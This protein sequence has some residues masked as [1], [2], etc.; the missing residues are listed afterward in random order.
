[1]SVASVHEVFDENGEIVDARVEKQLRGVATGL[2]HY[3][4]QNICPRFALEAMVR[5]QAA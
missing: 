2:L 4:D 1:V 3:V 5:E